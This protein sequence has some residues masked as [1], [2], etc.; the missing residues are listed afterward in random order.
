MYFD[1]TMRP[2]EHRRLEVEI[3]NVGAL[4]VAARSY[5]ADVYTIVN[6]G[7][8]GRLRDE[9]QTGTT[10][11][12]DYAT[13]SVD[14]HVGDLVRRSFTVA[15]PDD[16]EPGEYIASIVLEN[17]Q[18]IGGDGLVALAQI[19][20]QAIAVV[21]TVPGQRAP[22]LV[23]GTAAHKVVDGRSTVSIGI[24]NTG[25]IRLK[26]F[27][28]FAL[29]DASGSQVSQATLPIDTFYADT[30]TTV[31]VPLAAL[32][33][34]GTYSVHLTLEDAARGARAQ[35]DTLTFVVAGPPAVTTSLGVVPTLTEVIQ[36][37]APG[38][39]LAA[40]GIALGVG[41]LL[42]LTGILVAPRM[43]RARRS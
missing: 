24:G 13:E 22:A 17:D 29:F 30:S 31:E 4:R 34:P 33:L 3:A 41:V 43:R 1:L 10:L 21:V 37:S 26:P 28:T 38:A 11:W 7:F 12:L 27:A 2:G 8:G 19:V 14:L 6:G 42:V 32:L 5:A 40:W 20:R 39:P 9:P 36:G 18:P 16:A 25:N 15:V 23:I 35:D